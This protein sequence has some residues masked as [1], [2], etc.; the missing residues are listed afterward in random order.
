MGAFGEGPDTYIRFARGPL[1]DHVDLLTPPAGRSIL[2][3]SLSIYAIL[4]PPVG[5]ADVLINGST[6]HGYLLWLYEG[7]T[8][9]VVGQPQSYSLSGVMDIL[10]DVDEI[11]Q[12]IGPVA[13]NGTY[14]VIGYYKVV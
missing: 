12:G 10:L 14:S 2:L 9:A 7:V 13:G 1:V 11:L 3:H 6:T 4:V 8:T 5:T